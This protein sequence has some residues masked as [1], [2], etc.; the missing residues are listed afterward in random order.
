MRCIPRA[1]GPTLLTQVDARRRQKISG[2]R[3]ESVE[4]WRAGRNSMRV[5]TVLSGLAVLFTTLAYAHIILHH[6]SHASAQ[7]V[8][9]PYFLLVVT[10]LVIVGV[11]S[12]I[13]GILLLKSS[14]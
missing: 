1:G 10:L 8:H 12:L 14:R 2:L 5:L 9:S 13:G 4:D 11:L 6:L 7:D 3:K